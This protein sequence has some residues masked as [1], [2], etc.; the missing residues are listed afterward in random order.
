M[1]LHPTRAFQVTRRAHDI[2][3]IIYAVRC[4]CGYRAEVRDPRVAETMRRR[5]EVGL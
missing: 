2:T 5:H 1:T 4:L 3:F